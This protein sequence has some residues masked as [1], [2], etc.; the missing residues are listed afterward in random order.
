GRSGGQ[1]RFKGQDITGLT[2]DHVYRR[3]IARTF[4]LIQIF[5]E[6][7]VLE[8]MLMAAQERK[9]SLLGRLLRREERV[10]TDRAL[11]LL[12]YLGIGALRDNLASNLSYG[13]Q[14]LLALARPP[15]PPPTA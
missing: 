15:M 8:N 9:G 3:G 13:Q 5:P 7:T 1:V 10:E 11:G 6:M 4:Q 2:A 14:K 12:D